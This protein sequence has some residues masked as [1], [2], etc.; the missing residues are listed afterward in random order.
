MR[1]ES[2][3]I[4][5]VVPLQLFGVS[6]EQLGILDN[7][8][9]N[10]GIEDPVLVVDHYDDHRG[11]VALLLD[12]THRLRNAYD[13]DEARI[14]A[15]ILESDAELFAS[16]LLFAKMCRSLQELHEF[17]DWRWKGMLEE[18]NIWTVADL[19]VFHGSRARLFDRYSPAAY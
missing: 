18:R 19:P 10:G 11:E 1:F 17:Y 7:I 2:L 14:N 3:R 12:G 6:D 8:H 13:R 9:E 15:V 16:G 4:Q 5:S